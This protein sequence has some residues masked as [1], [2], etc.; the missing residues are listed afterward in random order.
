MPIQ[1]VLTWTN[2][3]IDPNGFPV[4]SICATLCCRILCFPINIY[5]HGG[6]VVPLRMAIAGVRSSNWLSGAPC[7]DIFSSAQ[8]RSWLIACEHL[9]AKLRTRQRR[10]ALGRHATQSLLWT[11]N[12][13][14]RQAPPLF[15]AFA[16]CLTSSFS[17]KP[18]H[19]ALYTKVMLWIF[20]NVVDRSTYLP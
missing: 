20:E 11:P 15:R 8:Q 4:K 17:P 12:P 19:Q 3:H 10:C 18:H 5:A 9:R 1:L 14:W 7:S 16:R 6:I 13:R 2:R